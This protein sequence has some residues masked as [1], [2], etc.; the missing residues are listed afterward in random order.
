MAGSHYDFLTRW[1]FDASPDEVWEVL[2]SED[3]VRWWPSVYLRADILE[4]GE[5]SGEGR[6]IDL[7]TKGW[8]PYTLRW[9]ARFRD[10]RRPR[11]F[12]VQ[13]TG[14]FEGRGVWTLEGSAGE[15]TVIYDWRIEAE[16]PL[17]RVL[18]PL[19]R[20]VFG[21]N[22]RWAMA[23]GEESVALELRRRRARDDSDLAA[24]PPP[25]GPTFRPAGTV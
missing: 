2:M 13:A 19:L 25:P 6:L 9:K 14:D 12:T 4:R 21:A 18:S 10:V 8:L 16:K 7:H 17:L 5:P 11:G 15:T 23:R 24:I 20:P 1:R 3:V 22:H